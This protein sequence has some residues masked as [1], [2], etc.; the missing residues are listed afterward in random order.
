[1]MSDE[2]FV[3]NVWE[4]YNNYIVSNSKE[5]FFEKDQYR[6]N[7]IKRTLST[8]LGCILIM[9]VTSSMVYANVIIYNIMFSQR[10]GKTNFADNP[11]YQYYKNMECMDGVYY[12]RVYEYSEYIELTKIWND[13]IEM[14]EKDFENSF[15]LIIAGQTYSTIGLYI[16]DV[17]VN[18]DKTCV[19]LKRKE[20]FS[21]ENT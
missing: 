20:N 13:L 5:K 4:K 12:K 2:K 11:G 3:K 18:E 15:V 1:M 8:L 21:A 17:Y 19:E 16:S 7:E 14:N 6:N 9:I 10:E